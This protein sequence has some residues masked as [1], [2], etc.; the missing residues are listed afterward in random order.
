MAIFHA[1]TSYV[2]RSTGSSVCAHAAYIS[3]SKVFEER[4]GNVYDYKNKG[5]EVLHSTLFVPDSLKGFDSPEKIWN[6]VEAFE[7]RVANMRYGKHK[8]PVLRVK[9]LAAKERF[10]STSS[11]GFKMECALPVE[12]TSAEKIELANRLAKDIFLSRD[13]VVQYA[14]HDIEGNPHVH[15]VSSFRRV[16]DG[17]FSKR[18]V[19]YKSSDIKDLRAQYANITNAYAKEMGYD[20]S[21]DHRSLEAQGIGRDPT[22][23][24]GWHASFK[25]LEESRI[26]QENAEIY[27]AN[28]SLF[29]KDSDELLKQV[30]ADKT[31]FSKEDLLTGLERVVGGDVD[32]FEV[33]RQRLDGVDVSSIKDRIEMFGV[34]CDKALGCHVIFEEA[35][36]NSK[37][38]AIHKDYVDL[39]EERN[40]LA[41]EILGD[42]GRYK[43]LM[44]K[45]GI[46]AETLS[47]MVRTD[48]G[49]YDGFSPFKVQDIP[50]DLRAGDMLDSL[51]KCY[52]ETLDQKFVDLFNLNN[53]GEGI[54]HESLYM[55]EGDLVT[56][57]AL[58]DIKEK[59]SEEIASRSLIDKIRYRAPDKLAD[60]AIKHQEKVSGYILSEVQIDAIRHLTGAQRL[61][62]LEGKAGT[63]KTTV[64]KAVSDAYK[65]AGYRV[66][67]TSFQGAAVGELSRS[68]GET[69]EGCYTLDKLN[70]SWNRLDQ[71]SG[72]GKQDNI[73]SPHE[74]TSKTVLIVDEA[75]MAPSRLM[76]PLLERAHEKGA[77]VILVGDPQQLGAIERG[78]Y[79][80]VL[81]EGSFVMEEIRRQ[82]NE[83]DREA[84]L[85]LSNGYI[86]EVLGHYATNTTIR[87]TSFASKLNLASD[88]VQGIK[89]DVYSG[90]DGLNKHT[91]SVLNHMA[92]AFRNQDVTDLNHMIQNGLVKQGILGDEVI[93]IFRGMHDLPVDDREAI[94]A[95]MG[96]KGDLSYRD[97]ETYFQESTGDERD[98]ISHKIKALMVRPGDKIL[99]TRNQTFQVPGPD[100]KTF[101]VYNGNA[102]VVR[103]YDHYD[104]ILTIE[105]EE[106]GRVDIPL[107]TYAHFDLGYAMT[108]NRSQGKTAPKTYVHLEN[109]NKATLSQN[110]VYVALT[111]HTE[112]TQL[113]TSTEYLGDQE[114]SCKVRSVSS[115]TYADV[116]DH[117]K[118]GGPN[119][120]METMQNLYETATK[121]KGLWGDIQGDVRDGKYDLKDHPK[122]GEFHSLKEA[123]KEISE[124]VLADLKNYQPYLSAVSY[125]EK[126]LQ[127]WAGQREHVSTD[128]D[129][130]MASYRDV[131]S[132]AAST[133]KEISAS[134]GN[135]S[136]HPDYKDFLHLQHKRNELAYK[137]TSFGIPKA[138][139]VEG[140][141]HSLMLLGKNEIKRLQ[142]HTQKYIDA[143]GKMSE[144][145]TISGKNMD[146]FYDKLRASIDVEG[147]VQK[148]LGEGKK[149][150]DS[151][152]FGPKGHLSVD[153]KTGVWTNF[154]AGLSG[155]LLGSHTKTGLLFQSEMHGNGTFKDTLLFAKDFVKDTEILDGIDRLLG[156]KKLPK[157]LLA[158]DKVS[159]AKRR[160]EISQFRRKSLEHDQSKKISMA[161]GYAK[162]TTPI[163]NTP[164][165][166]YLKGR[167]ITI[168]EYEAA[169]QEVRY[170]DVPQKIEDKWITT[171]SMT[172]IIRDEKNQIQGIQTTILTP[173]G[174]KDM[175]QSVPKRIQGVLSS[176]FVLIQKD[177]DN[178]NRVILAEGVE[179]ALSLKEAGIKGEIRS[180]L[181]I[182]N[183]K[184]QAGLDGKEVIIAADNDTH[185]G[186]ITL[187]KTL[188]DA[189][190]IH[191][192]TIIM[193]DTPG[194]DFNDVL[195]K[196]GISAVKAHFGLINDVLMKTIER[197]YSI[198]PE[199]DKEYAIKEA[200]NNGG[201]LP[202]LDKRYTLF[203]DE[204]TKSVY[205]D[206]SLEK[207]DASGIKDLL[208]ISKTEIDYAKTLS[209]GHPDQVQNSAYTASLLS[210]PEDVFQTLELHKKMAET[211]GIL[212]IQALES[213]LRKSHGVEI[214]TG[215]LITVCQEKVVEVTN[216]GRRLL[217]EKGDVKV[218]DHVFTK[219]STYLNHQIQHMG[220]YMPDDYK[221]SLKQEVALMKHEE[222]LDKSHRYDHSIGR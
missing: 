118:E 10:L 102:G 209:Q 144:A 72:R 19:Y 105:R 222:K 220:S 56:H 141:E 76:M 205:K 87:E 147:F 84:S 31:V 183:F 193:P 134:R 192:A 113:Y 217:Q 47:L 12:F 197:L 2:S 160:E 109:T 106:G 138:Y 69:A 22:R 15:F 28:Q 82:K 88:V 154:K 41:K 40:A 21:I 55:G 181:G 58:S 3:A 120:K 50:R 166:T 80:R 35:K 148:A 149:T 202:D 132:K 215:R 18:K 129:I 14:I 203:F 164:T 178:T 175:Q 188:N 152:R 195:K 95:S 126:T 61:L 11:T 32:A 200:L 45:V 191:N 20:F 63:G 211:L 119:I 49:F 133:W 163:N 46:S 173:D 185:K 218:G 66:I 186:N 101:T 53:I 190:E 171:P 111:R 107:N 137:L 112:K 153:L 98:R 146:G 127:R 30:I 96:V 99:F 159:E 174:K 25:L 17:D 78:S 44:A 70:N 79:G 91:P 204:H 140:K 169:Y 9:S 157:K 184:S 117:K 23:H 33:L 24:R 74:I 213:D 77:K 167:G 89:G 206:F 165:D 221:E 199:F 130:Q 131:A 108:I 124:T 110:L 145:H 136:E 6:Y 83:G 68:L 212:D 36:K 214:S 116:V 104:N 34:F 180:V 59:L 196:D 43:W 90:N 39:R 92:L 170:R 139:D 29:M 1:H 8:D 122:L 27:D 115:L 5:S 189:K 207:Q 161:Q 4:T 176:G 121:A 38:S 155:S 216:F 81:M 198:D 125:T 73:S 51:V 60:R 143:Q 64:L 71:K 177:T 179:T 97:I 128:K 85:S 48:I 182:N 42:V 93:P 168:K 156:D 201:R 123:R 16:V 162:K 26:Y 151:M 67:G 135:K 208:S 194:H 210:L 62:G 142:V 114:L 86:R 54:K 172:A 187:D 7:D 52:G 13:L 219:E 100:S 103:G 150:W 37:S 94:K 75:G 57:K 158:S 65:G